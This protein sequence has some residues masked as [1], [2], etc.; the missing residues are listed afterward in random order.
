MTAAIF[1]VIFFIRAADPAR[2]RARYQGKYGLSM[3]H[4]P[5]GMGGMK[6]DVLSEDV[7]ELIEDGP[8]SDP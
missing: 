7:K 6:L 8:R 2:F 3:S 5:V 4:P 1:P